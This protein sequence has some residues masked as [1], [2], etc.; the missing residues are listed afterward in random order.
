MKTLFKAL[1]D[2]QQECPPILKGTQGYGYQYA[3]LPTI[4]A[5]ILPILKKH[6]LGF[7]QL[8]EGTGIT[9]IVFHCESGESIK[10]YCEVP[11]GVVLKGMNSFQVM[12]SAYTYYKRYALSAAL[13]IITDT[14][15]DAA[16]EEVKTKKTSQ[17]T[18]N[19][20]PLTQAQKDAMPF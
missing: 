19:T 15:T 9:T 3:D 17:Y 5:V 14:D 18:E 7:T 4:F 2:F 8:L 16:G 20:T 13:G 12:G 1:A 11:Q 10:A 6:G